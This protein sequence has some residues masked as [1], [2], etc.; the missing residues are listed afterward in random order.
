MPAGTGLRCLHGRRDTIACA[1]T[2]GS[3]LPRLP[4]SELCSMGT[5]RG[6]LCLAKWVCNA[7]WHGPSRSPAD[8]RASCSL[9]THSGVASGGALQQAEAGAGF[10]T[11]EQKDFSGRPWGLPARPTATP[12]LGRPNFSR[13][14]LMPCHNRSSPEHRLV[15]NT[16]GQVGNASD[17][18]LAVLGSSQ[19]QVLHSGQAAQAAEEGRA[20][21]GSRLGWCRGACC[22]GFPAAPEP[23]SKT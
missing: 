13:I 3:V 5:L 22:A 17:A 20:G 4:R 7:S 23:R 14:Q 21:G 15:G 9:G 16:S 2:A 10:G 19:Q 11:P 6:L 18:A 8:I 12:P 1:L